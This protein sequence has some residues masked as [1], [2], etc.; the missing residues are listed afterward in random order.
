MP[1]YGTSLGV[2]PANG[3]AGDEVSSTYEG[4]HLTFYES[5]L[6]HPTHADVYVDKGDP[7]VVGREIVGVSFNSAAA[8]TDLIAIDSEGIWNLSVLANDDLGAVAVVGGDAL[9]INRTTCIISK[10]ADPAVNTPFGYALGAI[11]S[12]N[13]AVIAVKVH[14]DPSGIDLDDSIIVVSKSG[15]DTYGKGSW[16]SPI[17]TVAKAFTL[18]TATRK[19]IY[20]LPGTYTET[21]QLVWPSINDVTLKGLCDQGQVIINNATAANAVILI[22]PTVADVEAMYI[23]TL[24]IEN[25]TQVGLQIDNE[26][27]VAKLNI[28]LKG[29]EFDST[30]GDS[31]DVVHTSAADA[32]RIYADDCYFEELVDVNCANGGDRFI[33]TKCTLDGGFTSDTGAVTAIIAFAF[34]I[35]L[36]A[37]TIGHGTQVYTQVSCVLRAANMTYTDG[38]DAFST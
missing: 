31:M 1:N 18:V 9:F 26:H 10:I 23:E 22:H 35:L 36:A 33:F 5:E 16:C 12:G 21:A 17:L 32:I 29:V 6:A 37:P 24:C 27:M 38:T 34:C 30:T 13:T 11:T 7:C 8:L 4:R 3:T 14:F 19:F 15:N 20:V 25:A 2:Y 28:N